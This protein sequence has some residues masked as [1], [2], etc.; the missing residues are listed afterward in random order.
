MAAT[1][2]CPLVKSSPA[3]KAAS[4]LRNAPINLKPAGW[5]GGRQGM[6]WGFDCY[7][8]PWGVAFD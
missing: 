1:G 5:G 4:C 6:G 3:L 2:G 8:W 7:C